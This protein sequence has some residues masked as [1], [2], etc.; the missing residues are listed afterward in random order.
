[1]VGKLL[2]TKQHVGHKFGEFFSTKILG[3][4]I[5]YRKRL[6]LLL[7]KNKSRTKAKKK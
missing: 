2:I 3:E 6:K 4:R 1:M 5:A 7:K